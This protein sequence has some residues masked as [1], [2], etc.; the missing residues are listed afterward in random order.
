MQSHAGLNGCWPSPW[1]GP[2]PQV[3]NNRAG[4]QAIGA[5]FIGQ[6]TQ[7]AMRQEIQGSAR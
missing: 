6:D 7:H 5:R 3:S 1:Y 4:N 2:F